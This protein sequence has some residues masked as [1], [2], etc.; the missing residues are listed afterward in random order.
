MRMQQQSKNMA[1]EC[2]KIEAL[3]AESLSYRRSGERFGV[4]SSLIIRTM[5]TRADQGRYRKFLF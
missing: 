4:T 2:V 5:D 3:Y 1:N